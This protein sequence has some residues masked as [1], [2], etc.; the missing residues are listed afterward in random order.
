MKISEVFHIAKTQYELDFVDIDVVK[1]SHLYLDPFFISSRPDPWSVDTSRTIKSFFQYAIDLIK[2]G[3]IDEAKSLFV[4]LNEPNETCLGM[5]K[6]KPRGNGMG[7]DNAEQVFDSL[8]KS[9]AVETGLVENLEDTAIFIDGIG[10]DKVSDA[11]TNIIRKSLLQYTENQCE[12]WGIPLTPMAPSGFYWDIDSR[13]W[14]QTFCK[15]LIIGNTSYLLV[16][17]QAV[18]FYKDYIGQQ[19]HQHY[20]LNFLQGEHLQRNSG[21]VRVRQFKD[22]TKE[23]Y[24]TK[25]D[26]KDSEAPFSKELLRNFTRSHPD[27]FAKF[28]K[29]KAARL[30]PIQNEKITEMS[31]LE[32]IELLKK[33]LKDIQP[34]NDNASKY[35]KLMIGIAELIFYPHLTHPIKEKEINDGRKRID[36]TMDNSATSGFFHKLHDIHKIPA[37]Y[38][39]IECKNYTNDVE[40]PELDQLSG[41]MTVNSRMFGI[42]FC[43]N[44]KDVDLIKKRC[45]DYW[46][47]K[48]EL[49][50]VVTDSEILKWLDDIAVNPNAILADL[51][52]KQRDITVS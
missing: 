46:K 1:D 37:G 6:H 39:L 2:T 25:D 12:L 45:I 42:L 49:I 21:L 48:R 50:F 28:Q 52:T 5:S 51:E 41:R 33:E 27:I 15:R 38:A 8:M 35:H 32:I 43:R 24:V 31:L 18:T 3:L 9:K 14:Q 30:K 20:V 17:K 4:H 23:R 10:K 19:Y 34:G 44:L 11:T 16:P 40:N 22:G 29:E 13:S 26:I 36:F 7:K 47:Q